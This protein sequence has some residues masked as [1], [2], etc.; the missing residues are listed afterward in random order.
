LY[1]EEGRLLAGIG[2]GAAAEFA[3]EQFPRARSEIRVASAYFSV[4]GYN[5]GWKHIPRGVHLRILVGKGEKDRRSVRAAVVEELKR[6]LRAT[7]TDTDD[8]FR[9]VSAVVRRIHDGQFTIQVARSTEAPFHCKFYICDA[10]S[11]WHGSPNYSANGLQGQSEQAAAGYGSEHIQR[12]SQWFDAVAADA[13][14]LLAEVLAILEE[15]L[16][17]ATPFEAYLMALALLLGVAEHR[18]R[19]GA[20][21]PAYF[22]QALAA[23]AVDH[24]ARHGGAL[25]VVATGLGKTIIGAE[26]AARLQDDGTTRRVLLLAPNGVHAHWEDELKP[27]RVPVER[28]ANEI[29]FRPG[30]A[31]PHHQISRILEWLADAGAGSLIIVDEA[32]LY[33]NE[34]HAPAVRDRPSLVFERLGAAVRRGAHVLLLTA[35]PY[36]TNIDNLNSLLWLLPHRNGEDLVAPLPWRADSI[37]GF[38]ELPPVT[39]F[40]MRHLLRLARAREDE[41]ENGRPFVELSGE[42]RYLPRTLRVHRTSYTLPLQ[43]DVLTAFDADL[44]HQIGPTSQSYVD[45]DGG[46]HDSVS[47]SVYN[48]SMDAWLSSPAAFR[49]CIRKNLQTDGGDEPQLDFLPTSEID[50]ATQ[51]QNSEQRSLFAEA[52]SA[53]PVPRRV[54]PQRRVNGRGFEI[55]MRLPLEQRERGLSGLRDA[56]DT[57]KPDEVPDAKFSEL[58]S[59]LRVR[60]LE[61]GRKAVVFVTRLATAP[62]LMTRLQQAFENRLRVVSTVRRGRK[63]LH[64]LSPAARG[65]VLRRFS[66]ASHGD[67]ERDR[68]HVL[69]CTDADGIGVNLQ[70]ASA[71]VHYDLPRSADPLM[72]RIGRVMRLTA[73]PARV[74]HVHTFVPQAALEEPGPSGARGQIVERLAR[75]RRRDQRASLILGT[76]A[77]AGHPRL[78]VPLESDID[79]EDWIAKMDSLKSARATL[80]EHMEVFL[81]NRDRAEELAGRN[82]L[83]SARVFRGRAPQVVVIAARQGRH[84]VLV[85]EPAAG[86]LVSEDPLAALGLLSCASDD[87]LAEVPLSTVIA[88]ADAGIAA[89]CAL[90]EVPVDS[91]QRVCAV[92]L[93]PREH[94]GGLDQLLAVRGAAQ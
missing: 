13:H 48:N 39:A 35:S 87:P 37:Q 25:L 30:P 5:L 54:R 83:H 90:H 46:E 63:G 11:L 74:I 14:D 47:E 29:L 36:R 91:V 94:A 45:E 93:Q 24:I 27:P 75:I 85:Y 50:R 67:R 40:G 56:F 68:L 21:Q 55:P 92:Y 23:A 15:W 51:Q 10:V 22:Q 38:S 81:A 3:R 28:Y 65:A 9:A 82:T 17:M 43:D 69:I 6:E 19:E 62:Y 66:P 57:R 70:D 60:C 84:S 2:P 72:Q 53:P 78:N 73:D 80:A 61:E 26:V 77:M 52:E 59:I 16:Q 49:E 42:R 76:T 41:D 33:G 31:E 44:F 12:W 32:H 34:L 58:A 1:D 79:V 86:Q 18:V 89:W 71:I 4:K 7:G 8:L 64:L 20:K 88:A